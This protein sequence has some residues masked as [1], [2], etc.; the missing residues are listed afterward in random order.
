MTDGP[1]DGWT[2]PLIERREQVRQKCKGR[3]NNEKIVFTVCLKQNNNRGK[4]LEIR[5]ETFLPK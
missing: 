3:D 2:H 4:T 1:I 5:F